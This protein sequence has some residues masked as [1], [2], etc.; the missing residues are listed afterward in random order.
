MAASPKSDKHLRPDTRRI[1]SSATE[2]GVEG[3]EVVTLACDEGIRADTTLEALGK[4][5]PVFK[6]G[7][8]IREGR[9]IT[10]GNASQLSDGAAAQVLFERFG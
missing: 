3:R 10:A 8:R 4:L 7:M 2:R 5:K 1:A 9:N 6:G